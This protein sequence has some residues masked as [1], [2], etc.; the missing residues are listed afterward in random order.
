MRFENP[1]ILSI[2]VKALTFDVFGTVVDWRSTVVA[3]GERLSRRKGLDV[4]WPLF[5]DAWRQA[6]LHQTRAIARGELP[7]ITVDEMHERALDRLLDEFGVGEL[8]EPGKKEFNRV[9]HRL[10]PWPDTI[11]GLTRLKSRFVIAALSNGNMALL[12]NM[13]KNAGLPWDC[14]LSAELAGTYK[15]DPAVYLK[16]AE[17]LGLEPHKVM[18]V[19]AHA[20]D[21]RGAQA[22]GFR[23]A[24]I[25]RPLEYGPNGRIEQF[26]DGEFDFVATDLLHLAEQLDC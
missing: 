11:N 25:A 6:Y 16:A 18:M 2:D 15:P 24:A 7:W 14:I 21:L 5:A 19:A 26:P 20:H 1:A 23:T 12:T 10:N 13:A 8:P 22:V 9:W 4:D 3:D 17:L